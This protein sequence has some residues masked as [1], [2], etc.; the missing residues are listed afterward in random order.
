MNDTATK[1]CGWCGAP[2]TETLK[3]QRRTRLSS[4]TTFLSGPGTRFEACGDCAE[5]LS[6]RYLQ[7][8]VK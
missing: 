1:V 6:R 8:R 3:D 4:G 2:A 7:K 5:R